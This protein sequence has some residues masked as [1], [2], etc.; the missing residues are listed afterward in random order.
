MMKKKQP[1]V[2][3][4]IDIEKTLK[5]LKY[6]EENRSTIKNLLQ[7]NKNHSCYVLGRNEHSK[8]LVDNI[9]IDGFIDDY[10]KS[11]THWQ[12]KPII[13]Y[14]QT[15]ENA[16]VINC[17]LAISPLTAEKK[18]KQ[19]KE[20]TVINFYELL[21]SD[22][23]G[24]LTPDFIKSARNDLMKNFEEYKQVYNKLSDD[25]SRTIFNK[26]LS[27]RLTG[28]I[29]FMKGFSIR[30]ND[31]YFEPFIGDMKNATFADC[32]G[33]DGDTT[34][35]FIKR[36]PNHKH[37]H[38]FEPSRENL[39]KAKKRLEDKKQITYHPFA[40]SDQ[41][42]TLSFDANSG[43]ASAISI[44]GSNLVYAT[45]LDEQIPTNLSFIKMDLEG[46]EIKALSGSK[47]QI[48]QNHP[49]LAIAIYH[50][51]SDFWKI[52]KQILSNRSD[53]RIY[54]RHYTEGWSETIMYFIPYK[55]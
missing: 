17:S 13:K 6:P 11:A 39:R 24:G 44:K 21:Q 41:K 19:R 33:F 3:D 53:Y 31:Q 50:N 1:A 23:E 18:L 9:N 55:A 16:V 10:E 51:I 42:E 15:P 22:H 37:I 14:D 25:D 45:T 26:L 47:A 36:Y 7:K 54:I 27:Y 52:P 12:G 2:L 43:A 8:Q 4:I 28:N 5:D 38:F 30:V 46:W 29:G 20:L 40:L 34:E 48:K 35:E 49:T 32:G